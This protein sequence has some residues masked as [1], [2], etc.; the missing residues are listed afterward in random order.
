MGFYSKSFSFFQ[1]LFIVLRF[2]NVLF[3]KIIYS[4]NILKSVLSQ[5]NS[6]LQKSVQSVLSVFHRM[7]ISYGIGSITPASLNALI[8]K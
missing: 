5:Q 6:F 3:W 4:N 1:F 7:L 2:P 8:L